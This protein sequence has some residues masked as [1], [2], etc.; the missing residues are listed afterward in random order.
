MRTLISL[1]VV[2]IFFGTAST[3]AQV[4][5]EVSDITGIERIESTGMRSLYD[6]KYDGH[7]ASFRAEYVNH[8]DDGPSWALTVYGFTTDTTQVS[9][10]NTLL[11]QADGQQFEPTR[12]ESK[13]RT[14]N[15]YLLE[16]KR[17]VF[18]RSAFET[19]A[20]AQDVSLS[21]GSAQFVAIHPRRKDMRLI[22]DRVPATS[23]PQTASN[24]S[25]TNR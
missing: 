7:H 16:I 17:A 18:P 24:D 3:F 9:R 1:L 19:I 14:I 10:T 22:L 5:K 13:S 12:L 6:K 20:S 2:G 8:P 21:I 11:V 23:S 25:S 15:Q 4:K